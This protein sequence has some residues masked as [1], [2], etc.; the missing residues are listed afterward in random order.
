MLNNVMYLTRFLMLLVSFI[1]QILYVLKKVAFYRK[2]N[3]K[4]FQI[5]KYTKYYL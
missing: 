2:V 3:K 1:L 4:H 5:K